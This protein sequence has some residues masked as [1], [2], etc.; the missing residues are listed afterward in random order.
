[1]GARGSP[2]CLA[3]LF[4]M[5]GTGKTN[6]ERAGVVEYWTEEET[7]PPKVL[8]YRVRDDFLSNAEKSFYQVLRTVVADRALIFTKVGLWNIFYVPRPHENLKAKSQIDRKHVDFL[9]CEPATL[10]PVVAIELDDRS[11]QRPDRVQRDE[12]VEA[13]F[14]AA[15]LPLLR[16]PVQYAYD[17]RSLEAKLAPYLKSAQPTVEAARLNSSPKT[18]ASVAS[19]VPRCPKCGTLMVLRVAQ[20]GAYQGKRFYACPNYPKCKSLIPAE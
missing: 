11:H 9:L 3:A 4:G 7:F 5:G 20:R 1:M 12:F 18:R 13:V 10:Q 16:I 19:G 14:E 17:T 2:G 15:R 6:H 8:P